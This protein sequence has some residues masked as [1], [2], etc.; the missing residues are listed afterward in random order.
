V[1]AALLA[2]AVTGLVG[3]PVLTLPPQVQESSGLATSSVSDDWLFTHEDSG[4]GSDVLAVGLDGRLLAR[5]RLGVQ[6]RDWEDMAR[7]PDGD[8][9]TA[10]FLGDIGDNNARRELG[11]LV[12]QVP[13]PVPGLD[14]DGVVVDLP[15]T[16]SYR[17][18]YEDGPR[19]AEALL[20][21]PTTGR[22]HVVTKGLLGE[23]QVY[24]A[25][26]PLLPDSPNVLERVGTFEPDRTG[27]PG[28]PGIGRT[29]NVLVTAGDISPDGGRL[30]LRTYT[31]LYEWHV[32]NGDLA[33]ALG[34]DP[35]VTALPPTVQGE[36]LAYTRDGAAL[37]TS[38]EGEGAPVHRVPSAL[39]ADRPPD[40]LLD[41]ALR[42]D[43]PSRLVLAAGG[44]LLLCGLLLGSHRRRRRRADE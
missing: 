2:L 13:E 38:S 43:A 7:G 5:Y 35:V 18:R 22:V 17:L 19:D 30:A 4:S 28:G 1:R 29:A 24:A 33:A 44:A 10:L 15:P 26:V 39:P 8:G 27:T 3:E 37:L 20:V 12:H 9:G 42:G 40:A 16:A 25:P 11:L 32:D 6:A 14:G 36:G 31:D 21:H 23:P 41:D 34:D